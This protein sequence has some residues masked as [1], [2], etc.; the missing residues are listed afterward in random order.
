MTTTSKQTVRNVLKTIVLIL[1]VAAIGILGYRYYNRPVQTWNADSFE[2]RNPDKVGVKGQGQ[3]YWQAND[4]GQGFFVTD[5]SV[6]SGDNKTY[7]VSGAIGG[8]KGSTAT[9]S[10]GGQQFTSKNGF[11]TQCAQITVKDQRKITFKVES[12][13]LQVYRVDRKR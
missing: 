11:F 1:A 7:C 6:A 10:F 2:N 8:A 12:G 4:G 5:T 9:Y 13:E 3:K